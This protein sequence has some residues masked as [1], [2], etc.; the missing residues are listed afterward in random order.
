MLQEKDDMSNKRLVPY[1]C[2]VSLPYPFD[3]LIFTEQP[4]VYRQPY[5]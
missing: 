5:K 2:R 3:P 4:F 1:F